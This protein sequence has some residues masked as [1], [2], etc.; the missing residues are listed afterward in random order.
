M[1]YSRET[2]DYDINEL[3]YE[4]LQCKHE[5]DVHDLSEHINNYEELN[6]LILRETEVSKKEYNRLEKEYLDLEDSKK[7][8]VM[9]SETGFTSITIID[10]KETLLLTLPLERQSNYSLYL[11]SNDIFKNMVKLRDLN[12]KNELINLHLTKINNS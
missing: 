1:Y 10:N 7:K 4:L 9:R 3:S 6:E 8:N 12:K 11:M 5:M 2:K